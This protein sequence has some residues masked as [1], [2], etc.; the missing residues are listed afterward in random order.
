MDALVAH[1]VH[2]HLGHSVGGSVLLPL[3]PLL[4]VLAGWLVIV[5]GSACVDRFA[6]PVLWK[7]LELSSSF[8]T[9]T[10][11]TTSTSSSVVACQTHKAFES[12]LLV[13]K[14]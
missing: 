2:C 4:L 8:T 11:T 13:R 10:T 9:T 7:W 6:E 12:E 1:E 5:L 14:G 3:L